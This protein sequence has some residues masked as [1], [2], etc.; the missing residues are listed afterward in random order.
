VAS[1]ASLE[2]LPVGRDLGGEGGEQVLLEQSP[3]GVL[4]LLEQHQADQ[5]K[6]KS[7]VAEEVVAERGGRPQEQQVH[8]G[9]QQ[10]AAQSE[11]SEVSVGGVEDCEELLDNLLQR[12]LLWF[13]ESLR[14]VLLLL[15]F[16]LLDF[17]CKWELGLFQ[18]CCFLSFLSCCFLSFFRV[19]VCAAVFPATFLAVGVTENGLH[20]LLVFGDA[21][22]VVVLDEAGAVFLAVADCD[23]IVLSAAS[24][25][26]NWTVLEDLASL[27]L[28]V[29]LGRDFLLIV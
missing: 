2:D 11:L 1:P 15:E 18:S 4:L 25:F 29:L 21:V 14:N 23:H 26:T 16:F 17:I 10:V 3:G 6:R 9:L 12:G 28:V 20:F 27:L 7:T 13:G 8:V 5:K 22:D 19:G 24:A